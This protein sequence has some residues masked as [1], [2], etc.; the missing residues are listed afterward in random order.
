MQE[1]Q[2][3]HSTQACS[4]QPHGKGNSTSVKQESDLDMSEMVPGGRHGEVSEGK[5]CLTCEFGSVK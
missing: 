1:T 3:L 5:T 4:K 2:R